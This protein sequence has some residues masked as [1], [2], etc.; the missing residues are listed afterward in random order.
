MRK[1]PHHVEALL[2]AL[3]FRDSSSERLQQLQESQ[4]QDL[5]S[6]CDLMRLTLPLGQVCGGILPQ[7]VRK[8]IE[9]NLADNSERFVRIKAA[10]SELAGGLRNA[11]LECVVI[12]GFTQCPDYVE[13]PRLRLQS[14]I[15]LFCPMET[16]YKA[17]DVVASLGYRPDRRLDH[18]P[19]DHL[20]PMGRD[21]DWQWN[22]NFFD[23]DIPIGVELHFRLWDDTSTRILP[24]GL[25]LFWPRRVGRRVEDISFLGLRPEDNLGYVSLHLLRNMLR[26]EWMLH[27]V[28][29]LAQFL[30]AQAENDA[31]WQNWQ[32]LHDAPL[33]SLE[34]ISFRLARTWF[35]C[36][37]SEQVAD[38]IANLAPPIQQWFRQFSDSPL[39]GIFR[40][41]KDALW[42]NVALLESTR[43]Q[44]AVLRAT[45]LPSRIPPI[46][47]PGQGTTAEGKPK[48]FWPSQRH[49]KYGFYLVSRGFHHARTLPPTLW[50][51]LRW[52]WAGKGLDRGFWTFFGASFCFD[53]G[54]FI[55]FLL[56]NLYMVDRGA[57]TKLLGWVNGAL[58]LGALA[59]TIPAGLLADRFGLRKALLLCLAGV[60]VLSALR[61]VLVSEAP[62]I[63]L[64]FLSGAAA[65]IWAVCI[66][67]ALAQLTDEK[68]RPFAFSLVFSSGI[69]VGVLGGLFGG[70]L[71]GWLGR[72]LPTPTSAHVMQLAL[73][74]S[75]CI[76]GLGLLPAARLSFPAIPAREKKFYPRNRFL[77]RFLIAIGLWSLVTGSL[78]PFFNIYFS[79]YLH[80]SVSHIGMVFS[81]SQISQVLAILLAPLIYKK[82]GLVPGIMYTQIATAL[83]LGCLAAVP[84]ASA[85]VVMYAGYMAF[86]WMS[87]PGMYSLLMSE[88]AP[89]ERT[90]AS[91]LN[92]FVISLASTIA[93]TLAGQGIAR[94]GYP[95]VMAITA[96]VAVVAA[97]AFHLLLSNGATAAVPQPQS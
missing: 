24:P 79:Q 58:A 27:Y 11:N 31:F 14:D 22:G 59:G 87:E 3:Q 53:F 44:A 10:Y 62:Q 9:R 93:A 28:Y 54:G 52:W 42:L 25:D 39:T 34:A 69:G 49:A 21:T 91:A 23:P 61:T 89:S 92:F 43:D 63:A 80:M 7:W 82:Y 55:F 56:Y 8:R 51:G 90:G 57:S 64:A 74:I 85:A 97:V 48:R 33:R 96:V 36:D 71:P 41:N 60:A 29:E 5:L 70:L 18:L 4:W 38:E 83:T 35:A 94:F 19:S 73:L 12:K 72:I 88:V 37:L 81:L 84:V 86:Q 47:A 45:L 6:F 95:Q 40:P 77:P 76:I 50:R 30:H 17:R 68:N 1:L 78:G 46:G 75:C 66:S 32:D 2:A 13:N 16:V 26:G 20:A 67:P 15:D 65:S